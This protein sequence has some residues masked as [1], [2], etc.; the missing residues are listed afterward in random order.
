MTHHQHHHH[1]QLLKNKTHSWTKFLV[2]ATPAW[3]VIVQGV[4]VPRLSLHTVGG[5]SPD[6]RWPNTAQTGV[7]WVRSSSVVVNIWM[8]RCGRKKSSIFLSLKFLPRLFLAFKFLNIFS[9]LLLSK[10]RC[11]N[12][13]YWLGSQGDGG[14]LW[15]EVEGQ[16]VI[17][18]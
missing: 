1:H 13:L 17:M 4:S 14:N 11:E 6:G 16:E 10:N 7:K 15:G 5:V 8:C 9:Y 12:K 18:G 3:C 2:S